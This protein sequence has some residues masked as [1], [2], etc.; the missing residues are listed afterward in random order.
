MKPRSFTALICGYG[1]PKD[2]ATDPNYQAYMHPVVNYLFSHF[3]D[4][5]GTIVVNGGATD[6]FKPYKRT[7]AGE[8][9]KWLTEKIDEIGRSAQKINWRIL[10]R[11]KALTTVE[12]LLKFADILRSSTRSARSDSK[13]DVILIFCE[14]TRANRVRH[15]A[16]EIPTL[17]RAK[18]IPIDFDMSVRR[19]D[20]EAIKRS[21][22][23]FL[24]LELAAIDDPAGRKSLRNFAKEKLRIMRT[25]SPLEAHRQLPEILEKL[26]VKFRQ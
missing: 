5:N 12:T 17:Q 22:R 2:M 18:I 23:D 8:M 7:E 9:K 26:H 6:I 4:A 19:Y 11:P 14:A 24:R 21:E 15:L 3:C 1:V 16:R 13:N 25:Y 10:A 20:L